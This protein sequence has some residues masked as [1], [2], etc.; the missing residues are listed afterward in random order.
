MRGSRFPSLNLYNAKTGDRV[1]V[2]ST[3]LEMPEA[4]GKE[5]RYSPRSMALKSHT[6]TLEVGINLHFRNKK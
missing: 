2:E 3:E 6:V 1:S 5:G 4:T